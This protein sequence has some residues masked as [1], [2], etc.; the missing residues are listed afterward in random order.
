MKTMQVYYS[1]SR[2]YHILKHEILKVNQM[3]LGHNRTEH[4]PIRATLYG[5]IMVLKA[6]IF[7]F[8]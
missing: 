6:D 8:A 2:V 4:A 3:G 7:T 5:S 1:D